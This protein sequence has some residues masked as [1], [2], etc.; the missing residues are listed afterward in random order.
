MFAKKI[1]L[2]NYNRCYI[3]THT[4][5]LCINLNDSWNGLDVQ[6][7][8]LFVIKNYNNILVYNLGELNLNVN[9]FR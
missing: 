7:Q 1:I 3:L 8:I 6:L 9:I 5:T 2:T 4:F